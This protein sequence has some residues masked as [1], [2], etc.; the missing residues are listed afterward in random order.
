MAVQFHVCTI[1]IPKPHNITQAHR[2]CVL[3][4]SSFCHHFIHAGSDWHGKI[5]SGLCSCKGLIP[6]IT[7]KYLNSKYCTNEL[8]VADSDK[9]KS[10]FPVFF[11]DVD[12][13]Q[14]EKSKGVKYVISGVQWT[15]F[16]PKVDNYDDSLEGLIRGITEAGK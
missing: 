2:F 1:H 6:V 5:G 15:K 10:I 8:Y 12:L 13:E 7:T 14:S 4:V 9:K 3:Y 16:R 11:E